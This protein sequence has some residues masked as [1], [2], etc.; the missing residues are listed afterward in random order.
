V[1]KV[2][3]SANE[4]SPASRSMKLSRGALLQR[5]L[6]TLPS[7]SVVLPAPCAALI[8][9]VT[10]EGFTQADDKSWDFTL[11]SKKWQLATTPPP[12]A[13]HPDKVFHV[14]GQRSGAESASLELEVTFLTGGK[15]GLSELGKVDDVG[16]KLYGSVERAEIVAGTVRGSR[17]YEYTLKT[18]SGRRQTR[19]GVYQG[20]LYSLA[21]DLPS[22]AS[23]ALQDEAN[24]L[25]SSFK[26]FPVNIICLSQ[27][28]GGST[29][30]SGS[31]Y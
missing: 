17:Y 7:A 22:S 27:S 16:T 10:G 14:L 4:A 30:V 26:A 20:R 3:A 31:C 12:R 1:V 8:G 29:P 24:A 2:R 13:E 11:P 5:L 9:E 21:V 15:K 25:I 23:A 6:V 18:P 19:L 28:N